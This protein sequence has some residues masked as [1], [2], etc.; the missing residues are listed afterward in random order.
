MHS[1]SGYRKVKRRGFDVNPQDCVGRAGGNDTG[2]LLA[3]GAALP[4]CAEPA[5]METAVLLSIPA[6][7]ED[8]AT[9]VDH[10]G[11]MITT[12]KWMPGSKQPEWQW[13][14]F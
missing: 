14:G 13:Q 2:K 4:S 7:S 11:K 8:M 12:Q 9:L 1:K 3:S 5:S 10:T 6:S